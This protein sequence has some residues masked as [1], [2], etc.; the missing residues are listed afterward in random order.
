MWAESAV[1]IVPSTK[2]PLAVVVRF[3]L[4]GGASKAPSPIR[5]R[6]TSL[7][8]QYLNTR[9]WRIVGGPETVSETVTVFRTTLNIFGI[10]DR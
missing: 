10:V 6:P 7:L 3:P 4:V 5:L 8:Q 9:E 1:A 2:S